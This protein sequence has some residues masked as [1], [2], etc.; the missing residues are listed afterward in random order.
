MFSR[1]SKFQSAHRN[2]CED[3]ITALPR[4]K[5]RTFE[6]LVRQWECTYAMMSIALDDAVSFRARGELV[7]ARQ[8]VS[9]A[10]ELLE[11]LGGALNFLCETLTTRARRLR[12]L[13]CVEPLNTNFF[14]GNTGRSAASWNSIL[15]HILFGHRSRFFHKLRILSETV[16]HLSGEFREAAGDI[17]KGLATQ[18]SDCWERLECLHYDFN[19][20]LR[21]TEVVLKS[22][23]RILPS[24]QLAGLST[25]LDVAPII[26][27]RHAAVKP[28][29]SPA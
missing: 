8:Q 22:F 11:R 18:P 1:R 21:E 6:A 23:L 26:E 12:D 25:E 7:C 29:L 2:V 4:E 24:E 3:W 17:A 27:P 14:R 20:C 28:G 19:T 15:H 9:I 5:A 16:D 13:P 10:A